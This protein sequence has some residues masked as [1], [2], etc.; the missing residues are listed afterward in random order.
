MNK[1]QKLKLAE[2]LL[3]R[4]EIAGRVLSM[5]AVGMMIEDLEDLPF[6]KVFSI[7]QSWGK[8]SSEFP[9]PAKIREKLQPTE[10][11][12]DDGRD[13]AS[14]VIAAVSKFGSY[15]A[16]NAKEFIG[17]IGWECVKRSG[18]WVTLCSELTEENRGI[19][20]AQTRDLAMTLKKKS[21]NGTLATPQDFPNMLPDGSSK[22][23]LDLIQ[24]AIEKK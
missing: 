1:E 24:G 6:E 14:R 16:Q 13:I 18:G 4:A 5:P 7:L 23:V 20:F 9:H 12:L 11:D 3:A 21:I 17:E 10:N 15:Q 2:M 22:M 8:T 19:I